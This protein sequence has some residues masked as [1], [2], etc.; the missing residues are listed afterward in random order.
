MVK[1]NK[2]LYST[3]ATFSL[4]PKT[5]LNTSQRLKSLVDDLVP[6]KSS[7]YVPTSKESDV[8]LTGCGYKDRRSRIPPLPVELLW[9]GWSGTS[10]GCADRCGTLCVCTVQ[11]RRVRL[12]RVGSPGSP[13]HCPRLRSPLG[14]FSANRRQLD[15]NSMITQ[16]KKKKRKHP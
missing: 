15:S 5:G 12:C 10:W 7:T 9:A 1:W 3:K 2:Q 13:H 8:T 16:S 4:H 11:S 14:S 6:G